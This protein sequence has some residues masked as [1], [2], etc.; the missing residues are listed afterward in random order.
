[1]ACLVTK[2]QQ[3]SAKVRHVAARA[4]KIRLG[5]FIAAEDGTMNSLPQL[6]L[7]NK[8]QRP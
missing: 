2:V 7:S 5:N 8:G 6:S 3:H 4:T 1:V